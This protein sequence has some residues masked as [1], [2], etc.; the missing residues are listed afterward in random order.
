M[1]ELLYHY[2]FYPGFLTESLAIFMDHRCWFYLFSIFKTIFK[3]I[4]HD[5]TITSNNSYNYCG[6][7]NDGS[8]F[9]NFI[10]G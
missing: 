7:V 8:G 3:T 1:A 6:L 10:R 4:I 5:M 2:G 9:S